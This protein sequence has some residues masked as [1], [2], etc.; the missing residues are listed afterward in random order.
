MKTIGF[1]FSSLLLIS[2]NTSAD[3]RDD[4][5]YTR[6]RDKLGST[7]P[8]GNGVSVAHIEA[9]AEVTDTRVGKWMPDTSDSQF[10]GKTITDRSNS[11]DLNRFSGHATGVGKL[12]YGKDS[13]IA[14]GIQ[15]IHVFSADHW[16]EGGFL[17]TGN[18]ERPKISKAR[19][20]NHSWVGF[21]SDL[22]NENIMD[23]KVN[24]SA[25]RR[26]DWQIATDEAIHVVG[27]NNGTSNRPLLGSAFNVISVGRT[28]GNHAKGSFALDNVYTAGRTRPDIV[29]PQTT[30]SN[31]TPIVA[32][33]AALLIEQA[34]KDGIANSAAS[35][36]NRNGDVIYDGE[37]SEVI[38]AVIMAGADPNSSNS[39]VAP[40]L[41]VDNS[42]EIILAGEQDSLE[43]GDGAIAREGYDYDNSF[44]G[45]NGSNETGTYSFS[46]GPEGEFELTATLVWNIAI[47][48]GDEAIFDEA[49]LYDLD[50]LLFEVTG[51][52][53]SL[54][55][56][57]V[58]TLDNIE[59]LWALL[60]ADSDYKL[61]V[62]KKGGPFNWDYGLAWQVK[63]VPV[64]AAIW[65]FIT[66]IA[67]AFSLH[68]K[69]MR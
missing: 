49:T 39:S 68:R 24:A 67:G 27:M 13:S 52:D 65:F 9:A 14:P 56:S 23:L 6:L 34:H 22:K 45:A 66:A 41:N 59:N 19:V 3:Y 54:L 15:N 38:K 69:K 51:T 50:L 44:G 55:V 21:I 10:S 25:L 61:L 28:D 37:R 29:V 11:P 48:G 58:S 32:A 8:N 42:F 17:N 40:Q 5:G 35:T 47:A 26:L 63:A 62:T 2:S 18:P 43:D 31:A 36:V 1:I 46:T 57:S 33:T 4:I 64:P 20:S 30:T 12:F 7:L 60:D 16:L 53:E